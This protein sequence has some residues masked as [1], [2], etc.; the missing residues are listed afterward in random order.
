MSNR[1][2][3]DY[4]R[5]IRQSRSIQQLSEELDS[6]SREMQQIIGEI[7]SAWKGEASNVYLAK[8]LETKNNIQNTANNM[9][10][11]ARDIRWVAQSIK[12]ADEELARKINRY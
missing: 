7:Q 11:V 4:S 5:A 9:S 1:I 12:E 6:I 10:S 3:I 8:C 2:R